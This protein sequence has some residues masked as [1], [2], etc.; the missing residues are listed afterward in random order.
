[1]TSL[2][3]PSDCR[4][5]PLHYSGVGFTP[6]QPVGPSG[7]LILG[8]TPFSGARRVGLERLLKRAG[9]DP[10]EVGIGSIL[11]CAPH[12]WRAPAYHPLAIATANH[13]GPNISRVTKDAKAFLWMGELALQQG[14]GHV[15]IERQRGRYLQRPDGRWGVATH[16]PEFLLP[17]RG[18]ERKGE[19][20]PF[21]FTGVVIADLRRAMRLAR[22]GAPVIRPLR[23]EWD[24]PAWQF[25]QWVDNVAI[26]HLN[27]GG[28]LGYDIETPYGIKI[29]E[30]ERRIE[31]LNDNI[32][33]FSFSIDEEYGVS[34]QNLPEYAPIVRQLLAH[35][36][37]VKAG[38]NNHRFDDIIL[39]RHGFPVIGENWDLM[40]AWHILQSDLPMGLEYATSVLCPDTP[41]WKHLAAAEPGRYSALDAVVTIRLANALKEAL[42]ATGQWQLY[43]DHVELDP[44]LMD[45]GRFG[46]LLDQAMQDDLRVKLDAEKDRLLTEAQT[47]VKE[48]LKPRKRYK[49]L[50]KWAR[51]EFDH[52]ASRAV[53]RET[54]DSPARLFLPVD[55]TGKTTRCSH[56]GEEGVTKGK[57]FKG[58]KKNE[59]VAAG[60]AIDKVVS[61]VREWDEVLNFNPDST[62]QLMAYAAHHGHPI[63]KDKKDAEKPA[64]PGSHIA[65]LAK[66]YKKH[67]IYKITG[68]LKKVTK[69][70]GTYLY[71]ADANGLIHTTYDFTPSTG[72]M[73]SKNVNLQNVGKRKGN[74]W[75]QMAR[76]QLIARPGH[77]F[78]QAD[79]SAIEAVM[80]GWFMRDQN[81][82]EIARKSVHSYLA[83]FKLG[84][85]FTRSNVEL[86]KTE[87]KHLYDGCKITVHSCVTGDHE[88]LTPHGWVRFD[89][90][91]GQDIAAW[92]ASTRA[93]RFETPS[94]MHVHEVDGPLFDLHGHSVSAVCTSN[95]A[96]PMATGS[97]GRRFH[98]VETEAMVGRQ[99]RLPVTGTL[100]DTPASAY[101][102]TQVQLM[103][104]V[105]ADGH[106]TPS[107][108]VT[109]NLKKPRK[110]ERLRQLLAHIPH[111]ERQYGAVTRFYIGAVEA[112]DTLAMLTAET[113][114][115]LPILL[116]LPLTQRLLLLDEVLAWDGCKTGPSVRTY[117][118]SRKV[119]AEAVQ[120][121]AHVSGR[122]ALLRAH[123]SGMTTVSFNKR[124]DARVEALK[125]AQRD[126]TGKVYCPTVSTGYFLMRYRDR[127]CVTGN[128]SY[129]A[130][131]GALTLINDELF[132]TK[133]AA[134]EMQDALFLA[135]PGLS[136]WQDSV[137]WE[138]HTTGYLQNPWGWRHYFYRVLVKDPETGLLVPGD[139]SKRAVAL[140]P[141]SSAGMFM[142]DSLRLMGKS[143]Y[144]RFMPAHVSVHDSLCLEV[145][146]AMQDEARDYLVDLLT[147]PIPQMDGLRVG[148][149]VEVGENWGEMEPVLAVNLVDD[150]EWN[151]I[152]A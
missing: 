120:T 38:W 9:I 109:F 129:G 126:F 28:V 71:Q 81:Y 42:E 11:S 82:I 75:A 85:P 131:A 141:Q 40:W 49:Q 143:P 106:I 136:T 25:G 2:H 92:D 137:R 100:T 116:A 95:H 31:D 10:R 152:A 80:V 134:Q 132:P 77:V 29:Q 117:F 45:A 73:A 108:A 6:S 61:N 59:C 3:K 22:E 41:A 26:P 8:E 60:A 147:R 151:A 139:D 125:V 32:L 44:V 37:G 46:T 65:K 27:A 57:H 123:T 112:A 78:V 142:K 19:L 113:D 84:I 121:V 135:L 67:P 52:M 110:I 5:C 74:K 102:D 62:Q 150:P 35:P 101:T 47:A 72:R 34:I 15:G 39:T 127:V 87:H 56:C 58:G 93:L 119:N 96:W 83:C 4:G 20:K 103:A 24:I 18:K 133:K 145:P 111:R 122:Q 13:C 124:Q 48:E 36:S 51:G 14:G 99:G 115:D 118:T 1:M 105:Q 33:R 90:Y 43:L 114:F 68:E 7:L 79:S 144:R 12:G 50:P 86:V 23:P 21:R 76:K 16:P 63:G 66:R 69:T 53:I 130:T 70:R 64:M 149:E 88:V 104:A 148:C 30:Q 98:R 138:A 89:Q 91:A 140:K 54:P 55:T 97:T 128:S 17:K 94:A 107:G 146:F